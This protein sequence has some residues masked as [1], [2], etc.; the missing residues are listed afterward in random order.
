VGLPAAQFSLTWNN[1][2]AHAQKYTRGGG[3]EHRPQFLHTE[4]YYLTP[5]QILSIFTPRNIRKYEN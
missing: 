5:I 3:K 2:I 4:K 1:D